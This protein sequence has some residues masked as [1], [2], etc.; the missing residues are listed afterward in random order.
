MISPGAQGM[1]LG[2]CWSLPAAPTAS[3]CWNECCCWGITCCNDNVCLEGRE[4]RGCHLIPVQLG[5]CHLWASCVNGCVW[6]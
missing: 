1:S 5:H 2:S 4:L 6:L 3:A